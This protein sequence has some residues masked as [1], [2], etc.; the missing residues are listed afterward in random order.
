MNSEA[1][2]CALARASSPGVTAR[3]MARS[4][5]ATSLVRMTAMFRE[6][7]MTAEQLAFVVSKAIRCLREVSVD[8]L[9]PLVYQLL[10]LAGK[11]HKAAIMGG[12]AE[13]LGQLEAESLA[14]ETQSTLEDVVSSQPTVSTLDRLRPIQGTVMLH[15]V[16]AI[17]QDQVRSCAMQLICK[18]G[19]G[20]RQGAAQ[21]PKVVSGAEHVCGGSGAVGHARAA[22]RGRHL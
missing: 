7:P 8:E 4:W 21:A 11:G 16:F 3:A 6:V 14:H 1:R 2:S 19:A 20:T 17:K 10:L 12:I 5:P 22:P 9:P 18:F 15:V 13:Q